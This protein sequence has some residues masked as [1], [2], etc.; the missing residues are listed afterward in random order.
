[1]ETPVKRARFLKDRVEFCW[2]LSDQNI[3][4][5]ADAAEIQHH[6]L[7]DVLCAEGEL[8]D[9]LY[10][11]VEGRVEP[12]LPRPTSIGPGDLV[13]EIGLFV[14][15]HRRQTTVKV[16]STTATVM[17]I[18][19]AALDYFKIKLIE[20]FYARLAG[21]VANSLANLDWAEGKLFE[22]PTGQ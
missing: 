13:G 14:R 17:K 16:T 19:F 11:V 5:I 10:V 21:Y 2:E 9:C 18:P 12:D 4:D 22:E 1:M 15:P 3:L 7:N 6:R 8:A 20:H